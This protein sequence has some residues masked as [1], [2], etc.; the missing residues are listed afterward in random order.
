[1]EEITKISISSMKHIIVLLRNIMIK[2]ILAIRKIFCPHC[3][4]FKAII[5]YLPIKFVQSKCV[6]CGKEKYSEILINLK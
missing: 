3:F 4:A 5:A 2:I 1:M 6:N